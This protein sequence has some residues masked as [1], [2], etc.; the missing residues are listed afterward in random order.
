[1]IKAKKNFLVSRLINM[2]INIL[3]LSVAEVRVRLLVRLEAK[4]K[5][6]SCYIMFSI[7]LLQ[8]FCYY[9]QLIIMRIFM[10]YRVHSSDDM[11]IS[12]H[13]NPCDKEFIDKEMAMD[14]KA[15]TGHEIIERTLEK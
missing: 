14:H 1:M 4:T 8:A 15:S 12:Y 13:C 2:I 5:S 10:V 6:D 9:F 11:K 3:Q 7:F